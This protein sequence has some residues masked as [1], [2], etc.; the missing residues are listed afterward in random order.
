MKNLKTAPRRHRVE[1]FLCELRRNTINRPTKISISD[2]QSNYHIGKFGRVP[3]L[4]GFVQRYER[5]TWKWV[6]PS[7]IDR[8]AVAHYMKAQSDH[9]K[10]LDERRKN[11]NGIPAKPE[12]TDPQLS[13]GFGDITFPVRVKGTF[14]GFEFD[15]EINTI[16]NK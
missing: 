16:K 14:A 5:K 13:L 6:W 4:A 11:R 10:D 15:V 3:E 7:Q 1:N 9:Q 12:P 2:L 8:T